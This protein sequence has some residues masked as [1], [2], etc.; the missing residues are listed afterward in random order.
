MKRSLLAAAALVLLATAADAAPKLPEI[1]RGKWCGES[2]AM[3]R[4]TARDGF[5]ITGDGFDQDEI[6]C[7]LERL[8]LQK[9]TRRDSEYRATFQCIVA[10]D[11]KSHRR[12]YWTGFHDENHLE[13]FL[14]EANSTFTATGASK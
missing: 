13:L 1:F 8:T 7:R 4:C 2:H 11:T 14:I 6:G 10:A 3:E 12:Y 9:L 5:V